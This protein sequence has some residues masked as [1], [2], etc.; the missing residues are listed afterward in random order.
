MLVVLVAVWG[1]PGTQGLEP[2][3][4]MCWTGSLWA[5]RTTAAFSG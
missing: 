2:V 1:S 3:V 4:A 5:A